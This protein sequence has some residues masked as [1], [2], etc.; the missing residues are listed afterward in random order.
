MPGVLQLVQSTMGQLLEAAVSYAAAGEPV[1]VVLAGSSRRLECQMLVTGSGALTLD[2]GDTVLVWVPADD[3]PTGIVLGRVAPYEPGPTPVIDSAAFAVRPETLVL[4]AQGDVVIRNG[5]SP[6]KL[7][8]AGDLEV[9]C[10]SFTTR[11]HRLLRLLA[12]LIKLN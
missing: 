11:S 9:V 12:P 5:Q 7:S 4:E 10:R 2:P 1:S 6:I 8:A 3:A